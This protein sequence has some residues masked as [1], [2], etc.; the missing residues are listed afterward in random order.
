[1][2]ETCEAELQPHI[3]HQIYSVVIDI[4]QSKIY[5]QDDCDA[6]SKSPERSV[7]VVAEGGGC[8]LYPP[9]PVAGGCGALVFVC[10]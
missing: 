8:R 5:C 9:P 6:A 4:A 7:V 10:W 1:M 3:T 2:Q